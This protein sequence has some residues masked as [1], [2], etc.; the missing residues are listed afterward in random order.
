MPNCL[1]AFV[2][3]AFHNDDLA[4]PGANGCDRSSCC[5]LGEAWTN[6][7]KRNSCL[8]ID[9]LYVRPGRSGLVPGTQPERRRHTCFTARK[10]FKEASY[11]VGERV[12]VMKEYAATRANQWFPNC[13]LVRDI[14]QCMN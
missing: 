1:D 9:K 5:S 13:E 2:R 8:L 3:V 4:H 10:S 7:T 6:K 11:I 12:E 14:G